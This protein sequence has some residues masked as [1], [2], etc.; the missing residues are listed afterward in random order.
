MPPAASGSRSG[1]PSHAP[2]KVCNFLLWKSDLQGAAAES[3]F[4]DWQVPAVHD[5]P[6]DHGK[7]ESY[8]W[9]DGGEI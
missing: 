9:P 8:L 7:I 4:S 2:F 1:V 5:E 3:F 6:F